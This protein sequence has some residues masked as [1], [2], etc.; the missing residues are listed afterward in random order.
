[1]SRIEVV[2]KWKMCNVQCAMFSVQCLPP[3]KDVG[4]SQ[5]SNV[6]EYRNDMFLM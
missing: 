3:K 6:T 5:V 4:S 1:M 2:V